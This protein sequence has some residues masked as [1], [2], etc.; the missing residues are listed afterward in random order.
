MSIMEIKLLFFY[1]MNINYL[2]L[3]I[4]KNL[5]NNKNWFIEE[6]EE[7]KIENMWVAH[8]SWLVSK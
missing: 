6:E 4:F 1:I 8:N 5:F 3:I 2:I 7:E